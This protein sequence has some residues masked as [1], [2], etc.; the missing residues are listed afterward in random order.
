MHILTN[1]SRVFK[2]SR[3]FTLV[4]M[5]TV[6]IILGILAIGVS[7]FIIFGTKIFINSTSVSQVLSQSRFVMERMTR[8]LRNAVPNSLRVN[9][10]DNKTW[11]CLEFTPII[12]S[13]TYLSMP[14]NP[15]PASAQGTVVPSAGV[16]PGNN[17]LIYP[18]SP[19]DVYGDDQQR[20]PIESVNAGTVTFSEPIQFKQSS[21]RLRYFTTQNPISYCFFADG[22]IKRYSD[23]G[24][25]ANQPTPAQMDLG[26]INGRSVLMGQ[27][28]SMLVNGQSVLPISIKPATLQN[29]AMVILTPT[30]KVNGETFKYQQQVQVINVP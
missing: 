3:G 7:S 14:I 24:I 8:E 26:V 11:Q 9:D 10:G 16:K 22:N 27:G 29:N 2:Q 28:L 5:V 20:F 21:P 18:L 17:L 6:I 1:K 23:Y 30:F 13:S 12:S 19:V 4:E 25:Y 15:L